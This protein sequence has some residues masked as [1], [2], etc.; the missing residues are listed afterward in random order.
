MSHTE[1]SGTLILAARDAATSLLR[2][3]E[4]LEQRTA[5]RAAAAPA[6]EPAGYPPATPQP[7]PAA[8]GAVASFGRN[9]GKPLSTL[10]DRDLLWLAG[11]L[12]TSI[13]DP[14]KAAYR[15][16]NMADRAAVVA[17]LASRGVVA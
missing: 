6:P 14:E 2:L 17:V 9:K 13:A 1:T 8:S 4:V 3:A 15:Q 11:A 5:Q 12:Q 10:N 16:K 7:S